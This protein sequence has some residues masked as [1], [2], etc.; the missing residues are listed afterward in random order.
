M[1]VFRG[2]LT[3][4][5]LSSC[6][7]SS[8]GQTTTTVVPFLN[9]IPDARSGAMGDAGIA[10]KPDGNSASI[11]ASKLAFID[12]KFGM[13]ISYSPWLKS[14]V[15]DVSLG[16][17]SV[18]VKPDGSSSIS[19]SMRYFSVGS[20][21]LTGTDQQDLGSYKPVQLA[22]DA[23]YSRKL[24]E[25]F[26]I[27]TAFRYIVTSGSSLIDGPS[28]SGSAIKA[29]AADVSAYCEQPAVLF[30]REA[31]VS[32]GLSLSNISRAIQFE[33]DANRYYLPTTIK[34]GTAASFYLDD[35]SQFSFAVDLSEALHPVQYMNTG[36]GEQNPRRLN[37]KEK[38][39][40]SSGLEYTYNNQFALRAGYLHENSVLSNRRYPTFGAGFKFNSINL[41]L[42]YLAANI[43]K[44]PLANSLRFT[45][46][47]TFEK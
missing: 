22:L 41:D 28:E 18:F 40:V 16:Y 32:A 24:S 27:A 23:A 45:L 46:M 30:G 4:L 9:L 13:A 39:V 29:V 47:F 10:L 37:A 2:V 1:H 26:A 12:K 20:I 34:I 3:I 21:Q 17:L 33:A 7:F 35:L 38:M 36:A 25:H 8:A 6:Y 11:N 31:T 14:L 19:T 42:S 5:I 43:Q 15:P 44:S